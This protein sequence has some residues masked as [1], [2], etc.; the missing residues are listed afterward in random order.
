MRR[1]VSATEA[2]R[3]LGEPMACVVESNEVVIV[4]Y[5]GVPRV[6]IVSVEKYDEFERRLR[7]L[8][9]NALEDAKAPGN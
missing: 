8:V 7:S 5:I 6:G 4:H 9:S 1:I 3:H 2:R